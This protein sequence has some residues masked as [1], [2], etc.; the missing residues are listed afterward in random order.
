MTPNATRSQRAG[1]DGASSRPPEGQTATTS[2]SNEAST[3]FQLFDL[4]D[5]WDGS[6]ASQLGHSG[7]SRTRTSTIES[8]RGRSAVVSDAGSQVARPPPVLGMP[9]GS[10]ALRRDSSSVGLN[11][12]SGEWAVPNGKDEWRRHTM[13]E[14]GHIS[15]GHSGTNGLR[16]RLG[17]GARL[18]SHGDAAVPNGDCNE[19]QIVRTGRRALA[20]VVLPLGGVERCRARHRGMVCGRDPIG[21]AAHLRLSGGQLDCAGGAGAVRRRAGVSRRVRF[22]TAVMEGLVYFCGVVDRV[23]GDRGRMAAHALRAYCGRR[24]A[25]GVF[26]HHAFGGTQRFL[27]PGR[28]VGGRA[29]HGVRGH[30]A[31]VGTAVD[32]STPAGTAKVAV[33]RAAALLHPGGGVF[34]VLA[35]DRHHGDDDPDGAALGAPERPVQLQAADAHERRCA[36][37]QHRHHHWLV[38]QLGVDRPDATGQRHQPQ[39]RPAGELVHIRHRPGGH[40]QLVGV[41]V[42]A[43][44]RLTDAAHGPRER[45]RGSGGQAARVLR[46]GRGAA[47]VTHR[48]P[49]HSGGRSAVAERTVFV[50]ADA[51]QRRTDCRARAGHHHPGGRY[52]VVRRARGD[53]DRVVYDRGRGARLDSDAQTVGAD[54]SAAPVRGGRISV[55]LVARQVGARDQLSQAV[56][57]RHH[58]GAPRRR[59]RARQDRRHRDTRRGDVY[60]RGRRRFRRARLVP[61]ARRPAAHDH[62]RGVGGGH[63]GHRRQRADVH[64]GERQSGGAGHDHH[65][66][67]DPAASG[68][69]GENT[70]HAHHRRGVR[71][72]PGDGSVRRRRP[73][74]AIRGERARQSGHHRPAVRHLHHQRAAGQRDHQRGGGLH[75]VLHRSV[76]VLR[77]YLSRQPEPARGTL[78]DG[79]RG[80]L[81]LLAAHRPGHQP[82]GARCGQLPGRRL[83]QVGRAPTDCQRHRDG[84]GGLLV[85]QVVREG[86]RARVS[87]CPG[88]DDTHRTRAMRPV[89]R[90][91]TRS[92]AFGAATGRARVRWTRRTLG[93]GENAGGGR[94]RLDGRGGCI[95]PKAR[96]R[97]D[98]RQRIPVASW[99]HQ[100]QVFSSRR[101]PPLATARTGRTAVSGGKLHGGVAADGGR[102]RRH[103]VAQRR[104]AVPSGAQHLAA[105][106]R[107]P[108]AVFAGAGGAAWLPRLANT[109]GAVVR[110]VPVPCFPRRHACLVPD[111]VRVSPRGVR[112]HPMPTAGQSDEDA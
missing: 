57:R 83:D 46:G 111:A 31:D 30:P 88:H 13:S 27:Q 38:H 56:P 99:Q 49:D 2:G 39:D 65:R 101:R 62:R 36:G 61:A 102:H 54:A 16:H 78:C 68:R 50:R 80:Q 18:A 66:L 74:G 70:H 67:H 15:G 22:P 105:N 19:E 90:W 26:R 11:E 12:R 17:S 85:L 69:V 64:R 24:S 60:R 47:V 45:G 81:H 41:S 10:F 110:A 107:V 48:G 34:S 3:E 63:G 73:V 72:G 6:F 96:I 20:L 104:R 5:D 28:G 14:R 76:A 93:G 71:G 94:G 51:R 37:R 82:H 23:G 4:E 44:R 103:L 9:E 77:H 8:E 1:S 33:R 52:Y 32:L 21:G 55:Q 53:G 29:V 91:C 25:D 109:G 86:E 87:R 79:H 106:R 58:R 40:L 89:A 108:L 35:Q 95:H 97:W 75:H 92:A 42:G 59:H 100:S 98:D 7:A 112:P 43:V 84:A